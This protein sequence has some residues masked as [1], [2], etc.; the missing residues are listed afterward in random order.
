M[1]PESVGGRERSG[2][3]ACPWGPSFSS[4]SLWVSWEWAA[5][6][7][8]GMG[9]QRGYLGESRARGGMRGGRG[10][11]ERSAGPRRA[12]LGVGAAGTSRPGRGKG[13]QRPG[14]AASR[15]RGERGR[16]GGAWA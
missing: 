10:G 12:V 13:G 7:W 6:E 4:S 11:A 8:R 15:R 14:R 2:S 16:G 9:T 3:A 1:G 5:D